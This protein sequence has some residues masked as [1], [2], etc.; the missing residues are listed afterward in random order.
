MLYNEKDCNIEITC[1][2]FPIAFVAV[3]DPQD[4]RIFVNGCPLQDGFN[5]ALVH[6]TAEGTSVLGL[7]AD[8]GVFLSYVHEPEDIIQDGNIIGKYAVYNTKNGDK[9]LV[10]IY[11][12]YSE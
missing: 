4:K 1:G 7:S 11:Y 12:G 5:A 10:A 9:S 2:E 8:S 3:I 6:N